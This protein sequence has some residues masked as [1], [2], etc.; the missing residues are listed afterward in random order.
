MVKQKIP[1]MV[2]K[3]LPVYLRY[4]EYYGE[5]DRE[6]VSSF[7]LGQKLGLNPAQIRKDLA[8]F[9]EFGKKGLGYEV[10]FLT[11]KIRK[12]LGLNQEIPIAVI[13]GGNLGLAISRYNVY[14]GQ[15][16]KVTAIFDVDPGKVGLKVNG[17]PIKHVDDLPGEVA[18]EGI[19]IVIIAVPAPHAQQVADVAVKAGITAILNFAPAKLKV[20]S[21]VRIHAT[22]VTCELQTL[23]YYLQG[24]GVVPKAPAESLKADE[25]EINEVETTLDGKVVSTESE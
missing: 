13:G 4:L 21:F 8:Y 24:E 9:G 17:I 12:I 2:I 7:E 25:V 16:F 14:R 19:R 18:R 10:G 5:S 23:A 20:P 11:K 3:R 22:D 6:Y 15:N 1:E